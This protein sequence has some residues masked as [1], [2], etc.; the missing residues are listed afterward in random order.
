MPNNHFATVSLPPSTMKSSR[1]PSSRSTS[2]PP[3]TV[4]WQALDSA[5]EPT[6]SL[7]ERIKHIPM[8]C[9]VVGLVV[10]RPTY[11]S[12]YL[13]NVL[14]GKVTELD[15]SMNGLSVA[16]GSIWKSCYPDVHFPTDGRNRLESDRDMPQFDAPYWDLRSYLDL[17]T[18]AMWLVIPNVEMTIMLTT[19]N[20]PLEFS[21]S[22]E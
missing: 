2:P 9:V 19:Q 1:R 21:E 8:P 4:A 10:W 13:R 17:I 6:V 5:S 18:I 3:P 7:E 20:I 22:W 14:F 11:T 15:V 12:A 16:W